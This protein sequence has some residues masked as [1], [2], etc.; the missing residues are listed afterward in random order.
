VIFIK[1]IAYLK[2]CTTSRG[3]FDHLTS[4]LGYKNHQL[5]VKRMFSIIKDIKLNSNNI[6]SNNKMVW[7]LITKSINLRTN[8]FSNNNL[9][10]NLKSK[11]KWNRSERKHCT[12]LNKMDSSRNLKS[13]SSN[14]EIINEL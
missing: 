11:T 3:C 2:N 14:D 8:S 4:N 7:R 5:K 6:S 13:N 1:F 10:N 12:Y 9:L